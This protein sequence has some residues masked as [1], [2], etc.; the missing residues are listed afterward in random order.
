M[1]NFSKFSAGLSRHKSHQRLTA[2]GGLGGFKGC[3]VF[4]LFSVVF[5][6][7]ALTFGVETTALWRRQF[8]NNTFL[9]V[10]SVTSVVCR[11]IWDDA[12][13]SGLL[14]YIYHGPNAI[15]HTELLE[16]RGGGWDSPLDE[17]T[18]WDES[19]RLS[20][21]EEQ[22]YQWHQISADSSLWTPALLGDL[23]A[24]IRWQWQR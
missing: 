10:P 9:L 4:C 13:S 22:I 2:K 15:T 8:K 1:W 17:Y 6:K 16:M 11:V 21:W 18:P 19:E 20:E 24:Y 7:K 5:F 12:L 3:G 23:Y 14:F